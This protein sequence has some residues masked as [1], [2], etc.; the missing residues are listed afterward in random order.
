MQVRFPS[1][2]LTPKQVK[3]MNGPV[4]TYNLRQPKTWQQFKDM[5]HDLQSAYLRILAG[6]GYT[7]KN[8][9]AMFGTRETIYN[10]YMGKYH[11]GE[12]FFQKGKNLGNK[13]RHNGTLAKVAAKAA[14]V[15]EDHNIRVRNGS[16]S[17]HGT[18][19][20]I[21]D[22]AHRMMDEVNKYKVTFTFEAI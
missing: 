16:F 5:P 14:D 1:D 7:R 17:M 6:D 21:C 10:S 13:N 9:I 20:D 11:K 3:E 8:V 2:N 12:K 4:V 15:R 22:F 18:A 19:N